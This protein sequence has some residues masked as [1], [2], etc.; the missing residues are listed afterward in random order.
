MLILRG[1]QYKQFNYSTNPYAFNNLNSPL[2][3]AD[4]KNTRTNVVLTL[5]AKF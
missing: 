3:T 5:G 1:C 4:V 2:P